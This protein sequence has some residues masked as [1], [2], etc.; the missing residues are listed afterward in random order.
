MYYQKTKADIIAQS[1]A[2]CRPPPAVRAR[3]QIAAAGGGKPAQKRAFRYSAGRY[4]FFQSV[5]F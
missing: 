5:L 1:P 2:D 3:G 4:I